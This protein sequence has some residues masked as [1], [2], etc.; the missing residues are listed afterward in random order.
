[1]VDLVFLAAALPARTAAY[2]GNLWRPD[3]GNGI[4][5]ASGRD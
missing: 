4:S 2:L 3:G 5:P 1:M